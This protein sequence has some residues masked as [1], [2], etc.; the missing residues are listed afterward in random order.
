[1]DVRHIILSR[2][3]AGG[4]GVRRIAY[5]VGLHLVF[6]ALSL[7]PF[8]PPW[9]PEPPPAQNVTLVDIEALPPS[10]TRTIRE[11]TS[12]SKPRPAVNPDPVA[13]DR[14]VAENTGLVKLLKRE[15]ADRVA[16][17]I[18]PDS[19]APLSSSADAREDGTLLEAADKPIRGA[20]NAASKPGRSSA[21]IAMAG[22]T[23]VSIESPLKVDSATTEY[24][25]RSLE[26]INKVLDGGKGAIEILFK[27]A[28]ADRPELRGI[29]TV[30]FTISADGTVPAC[31][32]LSTTMDHAS[33]ENALV[34]RIRHLKFRPIPE[35]EV[36]LTYPIVFYPGT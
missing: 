14:R 28:L 17:P 30:E 22:R 7:V 4:L 11:L 36:T 19:A 18:L 26:E 31:R 8:R 29:V 5:A 35:G 25:G 15:R 21:Q 24:G 3:R 27:Q 20:A 32:I 16:D 13:R 9:P 6:L 12:E 33:L 10:T 34:R 23:M 1:M 2:E